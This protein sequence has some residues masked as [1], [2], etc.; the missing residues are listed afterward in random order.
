MKHVFLLLFGIFLFG[1]SYGGT[2]TYYSIATGNW[3]NVSGT[4]WSDTE[5]GSAVSAGDR[6]G[7]SDIAFI[8]SGHTVTLDE[9]ISNNPG[10]YGLTVYTGGTLLSAD[11]STILIG[12][13]RNFDIYG[14]AT[15]GCVNFKQGANIHIY[16]GG[17]FSTI[18]CANLEAGSVV[19]VNGTVYL[20]GNVNIDGEIYGGG[21]VEIASTAN[22]TGS[23]TVYGIPISSIS[24]GQT[25]T[26][27]TWQGDDLTTPTYWDVG[28]NWSNDTAPSE[29]THNVRI[30]GGLTN[31]PVISD[32]DNLC[33]DLII[34]NG[35]TLLIDDAHVL[36]INGD[37]NMETGSVLTIDPGAEL[38]VTG[39]VTNVENANI[40]INSDATGTGSF[41][42]TSNDV[43]ATI[44]RY[45][46]GNSNL[47]AQA[48][49]LVSVPLNSSNN[50]TSNLFL[51]SYLFDF[52]E[53]DGTWYGYGTA[54]TTALDVTKGFMI[55]YPGSS[56]TYSFAGKLNNGNFGCEVNYTDGDHGY[57]L[58][59]NPYAF[60][61]DW[62]AGAWTK[63]NI[64][65]S[66]WIWNPSHATPQYFYWNGSTGTLN[67]GKIAVGQAF[68]VR[69]NGS[70][71]VLSM[72]NSVKTTG[73][74]F[75]KETQ[76]LTNHLR[77]HVVANDYEDM[78]FVHFRPDATVGKD[79]ANDTEKL[80]GAEFAP[81]LY[82]LIG[83]EPVSINS[84]PFSS[85]EVLVPLAVSY[86]E[87]AQI[88]LTFE[89]IPSFD[90]NTS[91]YLQDQ[92]TGEMINLKQK[93]VYTYQ[94]VSTDDPQRFVLHFN[95]ITAIPE[96]ETNW[97][98]IYL[99]GDQLI[100][101]LP[102]AGSEQIQLDM[103]N[104]SGQKLYTNSLEVHGATAIPFEYPRGLYII[105]LT[106]NDQVMTEK[107]MR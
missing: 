104:A 5:G 75:Y 34:E 101:S 38:S 20:D 81:Q 74:T 44:K 89:D 64:G 28:E 93:P 66:I 45:I 61:I 46:T 67:N 19:N 35:A 84:L 80:F 53:S 3:S 91:I 21:T 39:T 12:A 55:Y 100:I 72:T 14:Q 63:T 87:D 43:N 94:H 37:L 106:M 56:H 85:D 51:G 31:Y 1:V 52:T 77:I 73:A 60:D 25:I 57:N 16:S 82:T 42:H 18:T 26:G 10:F 36:S 58:V 103:F 90:A 50:P 29:T 15:V 2:D 70:S 17:S 105:R 9:S 107:I 22:L 4:V 95:G 7:S 79:P 98:K 40:V 76:E 8:Y 92:N 48:Y 62:D 78:A 69:A 71:P 99:S 68:F 13:Q 86:Q 83:D 54:T 6:P 30:P 97:A 65:A 27:Y 47:D 32:D 23:G 41:Y 24:P 96:D 11:A 88:T 49:H 33:D 59:P 102:D